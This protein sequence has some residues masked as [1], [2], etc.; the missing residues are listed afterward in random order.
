MQTR[1]REVAASQSNQLPLYPTV[2]CTFALII[3]THGSIHQLLGVHTDMSSAACTAVASSHIMHK[4][5]NCS[6]SSIVNIVT[7]FDN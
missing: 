7:R 1:N 5:S 2:C 4:L 3:S 6:L